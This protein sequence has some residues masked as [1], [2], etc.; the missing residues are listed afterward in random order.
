LTTAGWRVLFVTA[1]DLRRPQQ[2][3]ARIGAALEA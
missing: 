2:L 3:L 1:E